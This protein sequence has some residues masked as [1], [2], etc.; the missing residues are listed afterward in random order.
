MNFQVGDRVRF[1]HQ[2]GEGVVSKIIDDIKVLVS[3]DGFDFPYLKDDLVKIDSEID[4]KIDFISENVIN[5]KHR[6][7]AKPKKKAKKKHKQ[8]PREID[9]HIHQVLDDY[10]GMSNSEI[11]NVQL[12]HFEKELNK[13][14]LNR[15]QKIVFIHGVGEGVLKHAL[16]QLLSHYDNVVFYDAS[17]SKYGFGATEVAIK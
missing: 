2:K 9:L 14:I 7:S 1:L 3:V 10:K 13:A 11:V 6:G 5:E 8:G 17:Y 15:E 16:Q 12:N 4:E